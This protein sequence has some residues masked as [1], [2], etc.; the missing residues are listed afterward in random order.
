M[1]VLK[2]ENLD[3]AIHKEAKLFVVRKYVAYISLPHFSSKNES[4]STTFP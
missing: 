2:S 4:F 1:A 3:H